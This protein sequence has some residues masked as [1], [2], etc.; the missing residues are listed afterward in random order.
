MELWEVI[1]ADKGYIGLEKLTTNNI[2]VPVTPT[3]NWPLTPEEVAFNNDFASI[4][5]IVENVFAQ[6]KKWKMCK[7]TFK[8]NGDLETAQE[9]HNQIWRA[10]CFLVNEFVVMHRSINNSFVVS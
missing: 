8:I 10:A 1:G 4:R 6:I 5:T 3:N 2:V 7:N 9:K